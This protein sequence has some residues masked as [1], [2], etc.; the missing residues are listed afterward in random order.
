M[1]GEG[2]VAVWTPMSTLFSTFNPEP[3]IRTTSEISQTRGYC[4]KVFV[5]SD[6]NQE[7][8]KTAQAVDDKGD[9]LQVEVKWTPED[10]KPGN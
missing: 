2:I 9:N 5:F 6:V 7:V 3:F 10:A 8:V 4:W 1:V